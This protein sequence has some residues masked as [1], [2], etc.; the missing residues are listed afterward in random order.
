MDRRW[1]DGL[2]VPTAVIRDGVV[3]YVNPSVIALTGVPTEQLLG[4]RFEAFVSPRDLEL[5]VDR[6]AARLRGETVP[7]SYQA[8]LVVAGRRFM[9]QIHAAVVGGEIVLQLLDVTDEASRG[10]RLAAL[11]QFGAMV[12]REHR[13]EDVY[14]GVREGLMALGLRCV[15]VSPQGEELEVA[16]VNTDRERQ[17]AWER[18]LGAP[19]GGARRP[20]TPLLRTAWRDGVS[21]CDDYVG[22]AARFMGVERR[23]LA[24]ADLP[25]NAVAVRVDVQGHPTALLVA[26]GDWLRAEDRPAFRLFGAQI[27]AALDAARAIAA[28]SR[29]NAELA[30]LNQLAGASG[31][32]SDLPGFLQRGSEL[33]R[34]TLGCVNLAVYLLVPDGQS[35]EL[36]HVTTPAPD[37]ARH[38]GRP[39][40]SGPFVGQALRDGASLVRLSRELPQPAARVMEG[41]GIATV[42]AVPLRYR[43]TERGVMVAAWAQ[44]RTTAECNLPL[45]EAM[46]SHF[47][48]AVYSHRLVGDLETRVGELTL[49]NE[50]ARAA[51]T[52]DPVRLLEDALRRVAAV[53]RC[54]VGAALLVE[55]DRLLPTARLGLGPEGAALT[56]EARVGEPLAGL[57]VAERRPV[58]FPGDVEETERLRLFRHR[59]GIHQT[60]AVPLLVKDRVLGV[61]VLARRRP[62]PFG[63][64]EVSLLSAIGAQLGVA[65]ENARAAAELARTQAQ[66]VQRERLAALGELAAVVAHEVRNPLGVIFNS[67]GALRRQVRSDGDAPML[68]QIVGEEA[69]RLNRMVGDLLDFA[70]PSKP[71]IRPEPIPNLLDQVLASA[72]A[73]AGGA[74]GVTVVREVDE[75]LPSVPVDGRQLRQALLNVVQNA[76]QA[77]PGGG[78]LTVRARREGHQLC[79]ELADTGPGV[80]PHLRQKVFE[81]FFTTRATGT[82]LGLAVVRRVAADHRGTASVDNGPGGGAVFSLR[83]PLDDGPGA[84]EKPADLA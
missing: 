64:G 25:L 81:P 3:V 8:E 54:E 7:A 53:F 40:R 21:F 82:G 41:M 69:D 42:A 19:L 11:A 44:A 75:G 4:K 34:D 32:E 50:L 62:E 43:S 79:L 60:V 84:V 61:L 10:M 38:L 51:A 74:P 16:F 52:L 27:S 15:M 6:Q 71:S 2:P 13:D 20:W 35:L 80:P 67:L 72:L 24:G 28:L 17:Q 9:A 56:G 14:R 33:V 83:L 78:I 39:P 65:A 49:L 47:A 73:T 23:A 70:R 76:I 36:V 37:L 77:M 45:L 68:L 31:L 58:R 22:E 26:V 12:Q 48:A 66:L 1:L 55:G 46:A 63:D 59:E 57:A 5:V 30:A 18:A 29:R